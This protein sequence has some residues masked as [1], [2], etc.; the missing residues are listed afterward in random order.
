MYNPVVELCKSFTTGYNL[1]MTQGDKI[2][3]I[4]LAAGRGTRMNHDLQKTLVPLSGKPMIKHLLESV[5]KSGIGDKPVIVVGYRKEEVMKELGNKYDYV[6][7]NEQLGTGHAVMSAQ[8]K[9]E[10]KSDHVLVLYGDHPLVRS[11]T[12]KKLAD[13]H[14]ETG[15]KITMAI[16][17]LP[18][19]EDWRTVF[20]SNFSRIIR[21]Q[22]GKIIK[23]IQ[24]KDANDEEKKVT[25]INPCYFCFEAKWLWSKLKTLK[26]DNVQ[27][28]Y[29]LTDLIELAMQEK[30]KIESID[31]NPEE[32][33]GANSKEEL[34]IL[35][36]FAPKTVQSI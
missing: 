6:V 35:E 36:K 8:A 1:E 11:E 9:L 31:I 18:D 17:K 27:K 32:A 3:I 24:F 20:Y 14:L 19:F 5:A 23:D 22:S 10:N 28:Q 21:D 13:K 33:L 26:R 7:Q 25:E 12:I 4:I 2:K 34:E 29:Y 16:V 30:I 15:G